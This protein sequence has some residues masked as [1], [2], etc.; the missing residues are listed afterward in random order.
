[1]RSNDS[2]VPPLTVFNT[3]GGTDGSDLVVTARERRARYWD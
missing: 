3:V 2:R 1:L